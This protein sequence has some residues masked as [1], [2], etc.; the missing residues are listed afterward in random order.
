MILTLSDFNQLKLGLVDLGPNSVMN[1]LLIKL[2]HEYACILSLKLPQFCC[3]GRHSFEKDPLCSP[4][5]LQVISPSFLLSLFALIIS[6]GTAA[7]K[8]QTSFLGNSMFITQKNQQSRL[9][10][11]VS[12]MCQLYWTG[13]SLI[14]QVVKNP[15]AMQEM[16]VQFLGL[17]DRL[18]KG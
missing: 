17:E 9:A 3:S 10:M 7:T 8:R 1:S 13:A 16:P 14:A 4:Y 5:L 6:F 12:F 11:T 18:E 15:P 2:V